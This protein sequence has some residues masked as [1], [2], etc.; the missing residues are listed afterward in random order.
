MQ[1]ASPTPKRSHDDVEPQTPTKQAR[2]YG[3]SFSPSPIKKLELA[4]QYSHWVLSH[5]VTHSAAHDR[6]SFDRYTHYD[7]YIYVNMEGQ[8]LYEIKGYGTVQVHT[9]RIW[10]E[11]PLQKRTVTLSNVLHIPAL[12]YN[13]LS[14]HYCLR[15]PKYSL[16]L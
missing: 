13:V 4:P 1:M 15:D 12:P 16:T 10:E 2:V 5:D 7:S 8:Q 6:K 9:Y 3:Q 14:V 11:H